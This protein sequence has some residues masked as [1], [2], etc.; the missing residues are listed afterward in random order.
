[1]GKRRGYLLIDPTVLDQQIEDKQL[2][3]WWIAEQIRV[4]RKT[5]SR[6]LAG[7]VKF[8]S[9]ENVSALASILECDIDELILKEDLAPTTAT[10]SK[11]AA[12]LIVDKGLKELLEPTYNHV[13]LEALVHSSINP[14]LPPATL[15]MLLLDLCHA[16]M[17]QWKNKEAEEHVRHALRIAQS[18]GDNKIRAK[19]HVSLANALSILQQLDDARDHY[20]LAEE[21]ARAENDKLTLARTLSNHANQWF[22]IGDYRSARA[23]LT[24]SLPLFALMHEETGKYVTGH[25]IAMR[26]KIFVDLALGEYEEAFALIPACAAISK[27]LRYRLYELSCELLQLYQEA[28]EKKAADGD[29]IRAI[30]KEIYSFTTDGDSVDIAAA[31]FMHMNDLPSAISLVKESFA[32]DISAFDHAAK[33]ECLAHLYVKNGEP[34]LAFASARIAFEFYEKEGYSGRARQ[35][36]ECFALKRMVRG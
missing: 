19:A 9:K 22:M 12:D 30:I 4:D 2:K 5:I 20:N 10:P 34:D 29:R 11:S 32:Q 25:C 7:T 1:M 26:L 36:D 18:I 14:D 23:L 6:W 13:L 31:A 8:A 3:I 21:F 17:R 24:E 28:Y 16:K 15:A 35:L 27:S 33:H